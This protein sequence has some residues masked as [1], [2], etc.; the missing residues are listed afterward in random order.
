[1]GWAMAVWLDISAS[2]LLLLSLVSYRH[3]RSADDRGR[4]LRTLVLVPAHNEERVIETC[5]RSLNA[6]S[7]QPS[8]PTVVVIADNCSDG[9]AES[10]R[11]AGATVWERSA[12]HAR[13]KGHALAWALKKAARELPQHEVIGIVDADCVALPT[14]CAGWSRAI[15]QGAA[16]AQADY[17]ISNPSASA[18]AARRWAG[19]ALRHRVRGLAK[20]RLKLSC[21][22]YGTGMAFSAETLRKLP[23][24]S[25]SVT[26]DAEYHARIVGQG[27]RVAFL[28]STAV[29]SPAPT[30]EAEA[31][32]Q[33]MRWESGNLAVARGSLPA[34]AWAGVRHRDARRLHLA[35]EQLVPPQSILTLAL[36]FTGT[37]AVAAH[38]RR[39][40]RA[41]IFGGLAQAGHVVIGLRAAQAPRVVWLALASAP[42]LMARKLSQFAR[43]GARR[44]PRDWIKTPR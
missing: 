8:Q 41:V 13:G 10:A 7:T 11:R 30:S 37:V 33:Q 40:V 25:F 6:Q 35:F 27:E 44:G 18:A 32:I 42:V 3:A 21:G 1:M 24:L 2:Y 43:I 26:E 14:L 28:A 34:L 36:L 16:A 12:E 38:Q 20:E 19:F 5:V 17:R 15:S 39:L 23:W 22:L 9:T 31:Q 4:A 29:E